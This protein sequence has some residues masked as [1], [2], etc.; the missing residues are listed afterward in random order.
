MRPAPENRAIS[1]IGGGALG[2]CT[3]QLAV[4]AIAD[5]PLADL[6]A[7]LAAHVRKQ[8]AR[9]EIGELAGVSHP[10]GVYLFYQPGTDTL[11]YAGKSTS[12]SFIERVP[13][14]FDSRKEAWM[15]YLPKHIMK[16]ELC[17]YATALA[18]ALALEVVLVGVD[19]SLD[20]GQVE[21]V[22]RGYLKPVLNS[23][24]RSFP[25]DMTLKSLCA[26]PICTIR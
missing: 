7:V 5:R 14:H 18:K 2:T 12:R 9:V 4:S 16:R 3:F 25:G 13:A 8:A 1:Q 11:M 10:H 21:A 24:K 19:E 17:D 15:N 6:H 20:G 26:R 23:T 22:F